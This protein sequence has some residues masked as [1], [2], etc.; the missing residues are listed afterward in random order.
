MGV[1]VLSMSCL[2]T[3]VTVVMGTDALIP[4]LPQDGFLSTWRELPIHLRIPLKI[5]RLQDS[6]ELVCCHL[7]PLAPGYNVDTE[8]GIPE[9]HEYR[10]LAAWCWQVKSANSG[11]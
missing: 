11:K 7:G 3:W 9:R 1:E 8:L 5:T 10:E 2:G 4:L 6:G